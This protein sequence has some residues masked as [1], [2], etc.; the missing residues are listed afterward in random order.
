MAAG[1]LITGGAGFIGS[2]AVEALVRAGR[3][4][5]VF[6]DFS[7]GSR[8]NLAPWLPRIE[9]VEGD[10]RDADAVREAARGCESI[11]HLAAIA[12]VQK[13]I[14][15][16]EAT[17]EVNVD[18]TE[19]VLV[20]AREAGVRRVVVASSC[21]VYGEPD[22]L[23][24]DEWQP[25]DPRSP[26]AA[27]KMAAERLCLSLCDRGGVD[28]GPLR[29]FNV[30][31]PRQDPSSDYS[32]VIARF[33]ERL[34]M[35]EPCTVYGDGKQSRDFVY[36]T[37]VIAALRLALDAR[38][39]GAQPL[40]VGTGVETSVHELLAALM[41]GTGRECEVVHAPAREGDVRHS[42]ASRNRAADQLGWEPEVRVADGLATTWAW[43]Q[44][45][46]SR[47]EDD[48]T[49]P[50]GDEDTPDNDEFASPDA[51][52]E[53]SAAV[54]ADPAPDFDLDL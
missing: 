18:G 41:Q 52:A 8:A 25:F 10:V 54:P 33:M 6:D 11:V 12:S 2:H 22:D 3:P 36:V 23:P 29:F 5:R 51:V 42:R 24:I 1:I 45:R 37:D 44:G 40:N 27:S 35:G 17:R 32:G 49:S 48:D 7:T 53:E 20:A 46:A 13:S 28:I 34:S 21:A 15:D 39:L 4:V 50:G 14:D 43:F 19:H 31:G 38:R 47:V 30:Y 26:Y 16:P 9:L